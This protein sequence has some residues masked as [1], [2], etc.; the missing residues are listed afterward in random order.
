LAKPSRIVIRVVM[1]EVKSSIQLEKGKYS[2]VMTKGRDELFW[3][4]DALGEWRT[5]ESPLLSLKLSRSR[6]KVTWS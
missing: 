5:N 4:G 6:A 1:K 2:F 3:I